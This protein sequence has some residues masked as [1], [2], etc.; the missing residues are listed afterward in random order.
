M[1]APPPSPLL[2]RTRT[3]VLV[4]LQDVLLTVR[5]HGGALP[6][7]P[8]V[9]RRLGARNVRLH[10]RNG[11]LARGRHVAVRVVVQWCGGGKR[12]R[13][14]AVRRGVVWRRWAEK[15]RRARTGGGK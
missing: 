5:G 8:A 15:M 2:R 10:A 14:C 13:A 6:G 11:A 12:V 4:H 7:H 9:Q 1:T 3:L